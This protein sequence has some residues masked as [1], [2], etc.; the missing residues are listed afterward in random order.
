MN[1]APA[2]C[3]VRLRFPINLPGGRLESVML[4]LDRMAPV[5]PDDERANIARIIGI[6]LS[7]IDEMTESDYV[8]ILLKIEELNNPRLS[9][10]A[11]L[12][13]V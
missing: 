10:G 2:R 7:L 9:R 12:C 8:R 5:N 6:P 13:A 1:Y 3:D 11:H 4:D